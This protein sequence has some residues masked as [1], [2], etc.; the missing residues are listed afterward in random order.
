[1]ILGLSTLLADALSMSVSD[2]VSSAADD[3]LQTMQRHTLA[4][5]PLDKLYAHL[6]QVYL[7]RGIILIFIYFLT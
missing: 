7:E 2:Y 4:Q 3:E 5:L 6:E 1:M